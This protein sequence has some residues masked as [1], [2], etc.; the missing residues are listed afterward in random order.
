MSRRWIIALFS[1]ILSF[2]LFFA[3]AAGVIPSQSRIIT[4][5]HTQEKVVALTFDADMTPKMLL[6]LKEGKVASWYNAPLIQELKNAKVPTTLFLTGMWIEAYATTTKELSEDPLFELGNHSYS[7]GGFTPGCFGLSKVPESHDLSEVKKT[8]ALLAR[9]TVRHVMLFRF[10]GLCFDKDDV[11]A[12]H[13]SGY[14]VIDGD[15][16]GDDGF[17]KEAHLIV[18]RVMRAVKPGSVIVLHM[19]GGPNA[20]Q[21]VVAVPVIIRKLKDEGYAFVKVSDLLVMH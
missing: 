6:R 19:H 1:L 9:Y 3:S 15:V 17:Q 8:D 11:V 4:H 13:A 14:T 18:D 21:T 12:V 16:Y 10:P 7:H 20:P 2:P 5:V